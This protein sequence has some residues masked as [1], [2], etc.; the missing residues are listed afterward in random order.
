MSFANPS[1]FSARAGQDEVSRLAWAFV[2]SLLLHLL[3]FGTY[4]TG[5]KLNWWQDWRWPAWVHP[6]RLLSELLKRNPPAPE[7]PREIPL[8]FVEVNPAA[9]TDDPPPDTK[10]YSD[11]N[12][13]AANPDPVAASTVPR[14]EGAQTDIVKTED[15]ERTKA[16]P[17]QPALP[18][19]TPA[20]QEQPEEKPKPT[21]TPGDLTMAKPEDIVRK[22]P[23]TTERPRPRTIQEAMMRPENA[24]RL[25]GKKMKQEGGVERRSVQSSLDVASSPFGA[26]D[27]AIVAAV[28]N[29]WYDLLDERKFTG[30]DNGRVMLKFRLN[31]DGS[32]SEMALVESTVDYT[33][34]LICQSAV[35]DPSP[36][37]PWPADMKRLVG[38]DYREVTFTF[39]YR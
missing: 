28:Q 24:N 6:P 33:L 32:V 8:L 17:L 19:A 14:I 20:P 37:R 23:G 18:A 26:Y 25:S 16:V 4:Q 9:A 39:Y 21:F 5:K 30:E 13:K 31:S 27:G 15:V 12:S 2:L 22:D 10:Y 3:V 38:A 29:R 7:K 34:A 11:K 35:R 36:Y 1:K